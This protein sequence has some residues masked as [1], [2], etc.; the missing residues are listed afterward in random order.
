MRVSHTN[1]VRLGRSVTGDLHRVKSHSSNF[2]QELRIARDP[3]RYI[4]SIIEGFNQEKDLLIP[5]SLFEGRK[6]VSF[7]IFILETNVNEISRIID[8]LEAFTNYKVKVRYFWK[9]RKVRSL[10][11]FK[12]PLSTKQTL[13]IRVVAHVVSFI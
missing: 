6:E 4:N 13:I 5:T 10:F 1:C 2:K 9:T 11:V 12:D 7:Q 3:F 8:K